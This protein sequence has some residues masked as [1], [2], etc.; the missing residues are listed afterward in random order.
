MTVLFQL[1]LDGIDE[2]SSTSKRDLET[3]SRLYSQNKYV[4]WHETLLC[5]NLLANSKCDKK[6]SQLTKYEKAHGFYVVFAL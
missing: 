2:H 5:Q 4:C 3:D 6:R 1:L